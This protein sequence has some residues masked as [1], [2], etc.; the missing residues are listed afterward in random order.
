MVQQFDTWIHALGAWGVLLLGLAAII[1]Y[2]FPPFPGDTILLLGGAYVVRGEQSLALVFIATTVGS[3]VGAAIDF[4]VGRWIGNRIEKQPESKHFLGLS[5]EK[6][7]ELEAKMRQRGSV[8]ILFNRFMPT[9]RSLLFVAAGA[10]RMNF[11]KV[12]LLGT[13]SAMAWNLLIL[14][15][16]YALGGNAEKLERLLS[17]YQRAFLIALAVVLLVLLARFLYKQ[18]RRPA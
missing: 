18:L 6:I 16:G 4:A 12:M 10:S 13:C 8:I 3:V 5:H 2:L 11:G 9:V 17:T 1:E 15:A 14:I 7:H